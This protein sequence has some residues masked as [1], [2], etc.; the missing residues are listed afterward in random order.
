MWDAYPVNPGHALVVPYRC[1]AN[2]FDATKQEKTSFLDLIDACKLIIDGQHHP[3][4]YNIGINAGFGAGQT[5]PHMHIHIIPRYAGDVPD[6]TGGV[7]GVV[8]G[9]RRY[10]DIPITHI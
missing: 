6:P 8:P 3:D 1:F 4:G 5:I 10:Y 2:Y 9:R 7:R